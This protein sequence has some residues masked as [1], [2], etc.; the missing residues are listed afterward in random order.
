MNGH[1][2]DDGLVG[3]DVVAVVVVVVVVIPVTMS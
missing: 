1:S 3:N 2:D